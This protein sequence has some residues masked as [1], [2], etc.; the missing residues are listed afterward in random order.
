MNWSRVIYTF[1]ALMCLTTV[2]GFLYDHNDITLF[3]AASINLISTLLKIGVRNMLSAELFA[4]SLVAD[5]HLLP[6]LVIV[7]NSGF[8]SIVFGLALGGLVANAFSMALI[9]IEA[10]KSRDDF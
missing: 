3:I 6:A 9:L 8:S 1:F 2:A 4:S 5:L 7:M 10:G